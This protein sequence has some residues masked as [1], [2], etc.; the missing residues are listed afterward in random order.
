M[1][2]LT[3]I[4]LDLSNYLLAAWQNFIALPPPLP[5]R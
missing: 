5:P 2:P 3:D 4:L 1:L